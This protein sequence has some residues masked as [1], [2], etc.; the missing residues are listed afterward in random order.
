MV[1]EDLDISLDERRRWCSKHKYYTLPS[2]LQGL[3]F[4]P[5][6]A[7]NIPYSRRGCKLC[8]RL[9]TSGSS[10]FL[11]SSHGEWLPKTG[12]CRSRRKPKPACLQIILLCPRSQLI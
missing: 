5:N 8:Q 2:S 10:S 12:C 1:R 7:G 3:L 4:W 9:L 11:V 6:H